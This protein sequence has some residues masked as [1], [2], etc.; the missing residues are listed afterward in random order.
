MEASPEALTNTAKPIIYL[1]GLPETP[2]KKRGRAFD[3]GYSVINREPY[4][5]AIQ[6]FVECLHLEPATSEG[7]SAPYRD[8]RCPFGPGYLERAD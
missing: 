7:V 3:R 1:D 8:R 4:S 6:A 2:G 5:R